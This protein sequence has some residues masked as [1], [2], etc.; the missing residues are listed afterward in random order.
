MARNKKAA[1]VVGVDVGGTKVMSGVVD[2]RWKVLG[3]SKKK[4]KAHKGSEAVIERIVGAVEE[5]VE[6][7]KTD[8]DSI[9]GVS[10]GFPAPLDS[11]K[12]VIYSAPNLVGWTNFP[13]ARTLEKALN[14]PV[15]ID[16]DVNMGTLGEKEFGAGSGARN[17]IGIFVGT[18]IGGGI[19]CEGK[20][21]AGR[22][23][24]AGE[25][26]HLVIDVNG[27]P[28]GCGSKGC[29]ES[30]A[31][32]NAMARAIR[33]AIDRGE[34]CLLAE[35]FKK[36]N[37]TQITSGDLLDAME[38]G[39][40]VVKGI[41]KDTSRYLGIAVGSLINLLGPEVVVL[42]GGV[43]EAL[44][45]YMMDRIRE[46][47]EKFSLPNARKGVRIAAAKLGDDAVFMGCVASGWER[48]KVARGE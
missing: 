32:R 45:S 42:G 48:F 11:E 6:A 23:G 25:I 30:L 5:S 35:E 37:T 33:A 29:L 15:V 21:L 19:I 31:S 22:N 12:G 41:L 40:K 18:G 27:P 47:A 28:C 43:I 8:W 10:I 16:N 17:M 34:K 14:C 38:K 44:K 2:P 4:T 46:E 3:R 36:D 9:A 39:D 26:G 20:L 13:L 1:I 7:A 24:T